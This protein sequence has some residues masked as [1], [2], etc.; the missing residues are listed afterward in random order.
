MENLKNLVEIDPH[1][2]IDSPMLG[3][4]ERINLARIQQVN[5]LIE[6][7][8]PKW[9]IYLLRKSKLFARLLGIFTVIQP[10]PKLESDLIRETIIL[11]SGSPANPKK[12]AESVFYVQDGRKVDEG[13]K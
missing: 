7:N 13:E 4:I 9:K 1:K 11:C 8:V 2:I 6:D 3:I 5:K 10:Q 12:I